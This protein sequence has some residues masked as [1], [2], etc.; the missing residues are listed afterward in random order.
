MYLTIQIINTLVNYLVK[1]DVFNE[2]D[3]HCRECQFVGNPDKFEIYCTK[4]GNVVQDQGY[5]NYIKK[6]DN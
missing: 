2:S 4:S 6:R 3:I 5:C 1:Y